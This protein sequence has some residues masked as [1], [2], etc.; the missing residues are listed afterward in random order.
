M[1][2]LNHVASVFHEIGTPEENYISKMTL[3]HIGEFLPRYVVPLAQVEE[4]IEAEPEDEEGRDGEQV[5]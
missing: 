1:T 2:N 3:F 4:M 5:R